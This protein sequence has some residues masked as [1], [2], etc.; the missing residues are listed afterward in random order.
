MTRRQYLDAL[1]RLMTADEI[2]RSAKNPTAY[3]SKTHILLH[4]VALRKLAA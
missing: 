4:Y 1:L 2:R 3:M